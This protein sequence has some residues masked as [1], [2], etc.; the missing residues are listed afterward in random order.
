MFMVYGF[1]SFEFAYRITSFERFSVDA[2]G[3]FVSPEASVFV[4]D[5]AWSQGWLQCMSRSYLDLL[6][7]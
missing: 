7:R 3:D 6:R 4:A 2:F 1:G 5:F